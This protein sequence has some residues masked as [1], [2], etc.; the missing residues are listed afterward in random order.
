MYADGTQL[1]IPVEPRNAASLDVV[2]STISRCTQAIQQWMTTNCLKLNGDKTEVLT[3]STPSLTKFQ[4]QSLCVCGVNVNVCDSVR[5][6]GVLFDRTF[7]MSANIA[8]ICKKAYYQIHLISK[9]RNEITEEAAKK[10][11][12]DNVLSHLDYC[13]SLL[14]GLPDNAISRLQR[15]QNCAARLVKRT[16]RRSHITPVLKDLHWLP[17]RFRIMYKINLLTFNALQNNGPMYITELLHEYRIH[18]YR[19]PCPFSRAP[20]LILS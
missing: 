7:C 16:S 1:Y 13:N 6:L 3:I 19:R 15:V 9:I 11:M 2:S 12:K 10:L 14:A 18:P 20:D 8:F 17:V 4:P 5:N